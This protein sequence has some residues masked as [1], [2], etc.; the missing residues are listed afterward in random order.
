M[1]TCWSL[2]YGWGFNRILLI[3]KRIMKLIAS[4]PYVRDHS[5]ES[6]SSVSKVTVHYWRKLTLKLDPVIASLQLWA[7]LLYSDYSL[8]SCCHKGEKPWET[9]DITLGKQT[10]IRGH[11]LNTR[12]PNLPVIWEFCVAFGIVIFLNHLTSESLKQCIQMTLWP[13]RLSPYLAH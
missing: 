13:R 3:F 4:K 7:V 11:V 2:V 9:M 1:Y 5:S 8:C 6:L 10:D 12:W